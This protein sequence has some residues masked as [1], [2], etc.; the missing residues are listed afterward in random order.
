MLNLETITRIWNVIVESNTFNFIVFVAIIA[1]IL[2]KIN[3]NGI[4]TSLQ[5]KIIKILDEAKKERE[6][7]KEKLLNAEKAVGNLG[8]ELK[9]LVNEA[10]KSAETISKKIISEAEKQLTDIETNAKKVIEAEEKFLISK[11][12][13]SVSKASVE[14]AKSHIQNVLEQ[15]PSLHEKY[16]NDSI[17]ELDRLNF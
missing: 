17:K 13:K 14:T 16:I 10:E 9:I 8:N 3:I 6:I 7:A 2:K 15:T 5:E 12:T 1:L 11:L 4:I